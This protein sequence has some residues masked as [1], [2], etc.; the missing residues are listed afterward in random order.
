MRRWMAVASL[1]VVA[2]CGG[3]NV[4][5]VG[6]ADAAVQSRDRP[7]NRVSSD[8]PGGV[9]LRRH[10]AVSAYEERGYAPVLPGV[11]RGAGHDARACADALV[12]GAR[13]GSGA[14]ALGRGALGARPVLVRTP[15]AGGF[16]GQRGDAVP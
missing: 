12:D 7:K 14:V 8:G 11:A 13:R 10:R 15:R 9:A 2:A 4:T 5:G 3:S 6:P 1:L 16:S